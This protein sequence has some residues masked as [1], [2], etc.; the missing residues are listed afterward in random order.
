SLSY[1][2]VLRCWKDTPGEGDCKGIQ[3]WLPAVG[4][5]LTSYAGWVQAHDGEGL[6]RPDPQLG[7]HL[8]NLPA[9]VQHLLNRTT[10][11][12]L[13]VLRRSGHDKQSPLPDPKATG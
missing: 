2:G 3:S 11:E 6:R 5:T 4:L 10:P 1:S 7:R 13:R 8:R 12:L 9:P